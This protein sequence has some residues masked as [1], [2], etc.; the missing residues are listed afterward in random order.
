[1]IKTLKG[2]QPE[3]LTFAAYHKALG[4]FFDFPTKEISLTDLATNVRISKSSASTVVEQLVQEG[5]LKKEALGRVWRLSC[6]QNHV[7]T[8]SRKIG[9]NLIRIYESGIIQEVN[10]R[11]PG[12]KAMILFGS[13]RRGDDT[14]L[15]D[16][17]IAVEI[18]GD[19]ETK[20]E[21]LGK[22]SQLNYRTNVTVNLCIFSRSKV[23]LNLFSNMVN[24]IVLQGFLE[25]KL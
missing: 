4:W 19:I 23:D 9:Y 10:K 2:V 1:M 6:N 7:F 13:Y 11:V 14:E 12:I 21:P 3:D 15:S 20:I 22:L 8:I 5:F 25:V 17:D 18:L 16:I 24:G